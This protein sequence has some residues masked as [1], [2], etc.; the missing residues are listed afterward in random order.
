MPAHIYNRTG[1]F[2]D[3]IAVNRAAIEA[4]EAF[5][6]GAG[7]AASPLYRFGY[8]PHNVHFLL[9]AAQNAGDK[10]AA[11]AAAEKLAGVVS[12]DV[13]GELAWVQAILTAP[14]SAHAQ[15]SDIETIMALPDPGDRFPFVKGF[16]HYARGTALARAGEADL[17]WDEVYAIEEMLEK[18][19]FSDLEA[20][21]L[22]A[23]DVLGIAKHVV[24][25]RIEAEAANWHAAIHHLDE[26]IALEARIAYMEP[27]YWPYPVHQT[28]GAVLLQAGRPADAARAFEIALAD[29]PSNGWAAW[30]LWQAQATLFDLAASEVAED[31]FRQAWLGDESLLS[32][33]RL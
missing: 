18:T 14:Y 23:R 1:R 20:Q 17:A 16:W 4:D 22:P 6:K 30:G 13:A 12:D 19:D 21:Y 5:L 9:V 10:D 7:D 25:G 11:I 28:L 29:T 15:F 24:E 2:A 27:P 26:A 33:D 8:Y 31:A 3:S 32:L